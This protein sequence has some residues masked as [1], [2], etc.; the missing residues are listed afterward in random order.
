MYERQF[1]D[2]RLQVYACAYHYCLLELGEDVVTMEVIG[3]DGEVLDKATI[4]NSNRGP[5]ATIP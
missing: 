1:N 5:R 4:T 3:Q 2:P